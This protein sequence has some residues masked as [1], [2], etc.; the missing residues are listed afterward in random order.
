MTYMHVASEHVRLSRSMNCCIYMVTGQNGVH[1]R[2]KGLDFAY[3]VNLLSVWP[4]LLG[5]RYVPVYGRKYCIYKSHF[6]QLQ[7]RI[8][9]HI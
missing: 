2:F 1:V 8:F 6:G 9:N 4:F 3:G 7:D 5:S